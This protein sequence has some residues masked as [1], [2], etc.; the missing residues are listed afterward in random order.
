MLGSTNPLKRLATK[1]MHRDDEFSSW[2]KRSF[3]K[4]TWD[5]VLMSKRAA[6][7]SDTNSI[8]LKFAA[9][10]GRADDWPFVENILRQ[11]SFLQF[12]HDLCSLVEKAWIAIAD[13]HPLLEAFH[14][15]TAQA[16]LG[17]SNCTWAAL[18]REPLLLLTLPEEVLCCPPILRVVL[19]TFSVILRAAEKETVRAVKADAAR[20]AVASCAAAVAATEPE[21]ML[22][23]HGI[24]PEAAHLLT[25]VIASRCLL[26]L[27]AFG[28]PEIIDIVVDWLCANGPICLSIASRQGVS[29]IEMTNL[30]SRSSQDA[31]CS[32]NYVF[33]EQLA[34][35]LRH[36]HLEVQLSGIT[37]A[38]ALSTTN[39]LKTGSPEALETTLLCATAISSFALTLR[40]APSRF[41]LEVLAAGLANLETLVSHQP[42]QFHASE[43][44]ISA[45]GVF[46]APEYWPILPRLLSRALFPQSVL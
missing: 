13:C 6:P 40:L 30:S 31:A 10:C 34:G 12:D 29:L 39:V 41:H 46:R 7:F 17:M 28:D 4:K 44:L 18:A 1:D 45:L 33:R 22:R 15:A 2:P 5:S 37:L 21:S 36:E 23:P 8:R 11:R 35:M 42:P 26:G 19:T 20:A 24:D 25:V 14:L 32:A 3:S 38:A 16:L 27:C 43:G 9:S